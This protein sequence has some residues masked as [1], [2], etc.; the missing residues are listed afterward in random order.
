[1]IKTFTPDLA[2]QALQKNN[3]NRA[4]SKATVER[5]AIAMSNGEWVLNGEPIIFDSNGNLVSGQH[6]LSACIKSGVDLNTYVVTGVDPETRVTVD[7]GK[8]RTLGDVFSIDSRK[9]TTA[10][11]AAVRAIALIN[12]MTDKWNRISHT[13]GKEILLSHPTIEFWVDEFCR[14]RNARSICSSSLAAVLCLAAERHGTQICL[15]FINQLNDGVGLQPG[16]P[17]LVLRNR[18]QTRRG[19]SFS[20]EA[21]TAFYIKAINAHIKNRPLGLLRISAEETFPQIV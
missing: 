17:A 5:Y 14:A 9:N 16:D 7:T 21:L 4:L 13:K 19:V 6:R 11:A 12:G 2:S 8:T 3:C 15:S 1:M 10:L 20:Q 18:L